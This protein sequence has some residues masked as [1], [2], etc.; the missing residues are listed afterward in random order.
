MQKYLYKETLN[1]DCSDTYF[2][3]LVC[4]GEKLGVEVKNS[5]GECETCIIEDK[6][7]SVFEFLKVLADGAVCPVHVPDILHD[8]K[9]ERFLDKLSGNLIKAYLNT[10]L[11]CG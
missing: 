4:D 3:Y 5:G 9:T 2:Y 8:R 7:E 6:E 11:H 10:T 1:D